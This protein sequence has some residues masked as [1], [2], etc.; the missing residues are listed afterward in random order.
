MKTRLLVV[1]NVRYML[2]SNDGVLWELHWGFDC[3]EFSDC[4]AHKLDYWRQKGTIVGEAKDRKTKIILI[5][6]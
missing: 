6:R 4:G 1:K 2:I 5:R 3:K